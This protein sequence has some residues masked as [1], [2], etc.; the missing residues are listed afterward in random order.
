M[1]KAFVLTPIMMEKIRAEKAK[2]KSPR[3]I[4]KKFG[5]HPHV[6]KDVCNER[7]KVIPSTK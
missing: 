4:S 7:V 3:E 5:C 1:N 6:V 2:G